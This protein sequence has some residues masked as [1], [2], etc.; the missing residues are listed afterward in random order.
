MKLS[1]KKLEIL[2]ENIKFRGGLLGLKDFMMILKLLLLRANISG[3]KGKNS[4]QQRVVKCF[5]CR[6]EAQE[7]AYQADDLDAYDSDCD[8][9][10]TAKAV[11][12]AKLSSYRSDVLFE[13]THSENTHNAMLNKSVQEMLYY[14]QTHLVNYPENEITNF[15]KCFVSQQELSNEQAFRSQTSH[16]NTDQS[17]SLPVKI[18]APRELPKCFE[19]QK[20]QFLIENDQLLD[21]IISQDIVNIVVNSSVVMNTSVNVNSS[22]AM[23][24]SVNYVE[25]CNKC[26]KLEAELIKQHN[27]VEK[28]DIKNDLRKLIG[29]DIVD[30]AAQ[31]SNATTIAPRMYKLDPVTLAHKDKN[32]RETHTY[33]LKY[34][35]EQAAILREIVKQAKLL[36]LLDSASYFAY[37]FV[38]LIQELLAY[39]RDTCLDIHKPSEKLV[40]VTP[41]NKK[42]TVRFDK[43]VTSSRVNWSTKSS[44][45][46]STDNTKNDR[47]MQISSSTHKK[48]KVEDHSRIVKSCLNKPN[49]V[50]EPF[51]NA[52][53]QHS[54]LNTNSELLCV[55]CNSSMFDARHELFFLEFVSDMN[56]SFKYKSVKKSK[57]K[58]EWKPTGKVFTKIRYNWRPTRRTFTLVR[59]ACPLTKITAT[60]KVP[61]R[62]PIPL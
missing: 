17:A 6:R 18:K 34:T 53:V 47:I 24:E 33:Y 16:P 57:K 44:K 55:K 61:L 37:K 31:V 56:A 12:M 36:N 1:M 42:K 25:Q 15:G 26:L 62:E 21:Q 60:N 59:N 4:G 30:N 3:T 48:N 40:V 28:D 32:N 23:N 54:K 29:K 14:E 9:F 19:I 58:E 50:V 13:V 7:S 45:S 41:I 10:S 49:C 27:K 51:G 38:K 5:N 43:P 20:K 52:N 35:M 8:D 11:L 39:V 2:K 46:K 22:A